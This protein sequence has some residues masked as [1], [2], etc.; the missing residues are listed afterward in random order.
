MTLVNLITA[1][2]SRNLIPER[3]ILSND[4]S[5]MFYFF[6]PDSLSEYAIIE[7]Y[8]DQSM[9]G[10]FSIDGVAW[11]FTDENAED[12]LRKIARYVEGT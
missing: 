2:W 8:G 11:E 4:E 7:W 10:L 3:I 9:V 6:K 12:K 5:L 1:L